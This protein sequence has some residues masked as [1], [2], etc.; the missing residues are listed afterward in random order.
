MKI[1][2]CD[3]C[4]RDMGMNNMEGISHIENKT[5]SIDWRVYVRKT[6]LTEGK[7]LDYCKSCVA[8]LLLSLKEVV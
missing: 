2:I 8:E 7:Q 5:Y 1:T 3:N 6:D 4:K